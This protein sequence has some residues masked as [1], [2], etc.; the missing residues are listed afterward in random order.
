MTNINDISGN[1]IIV[2]PAKTHQRLRLLAALYDITIEE[3]VS[4]LSY[5]VISANEA[6]KIIENFIRYYEPLP[7]NQVLDLSNDELLKELNMIK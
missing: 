1:R 5:Q 2:V 4:R 6:Q 3:V 7:V